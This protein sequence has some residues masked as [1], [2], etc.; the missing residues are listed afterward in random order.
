MAARAST[1]TTDAVANTLA[2]PRLRYMGSKYRLI[3][4]LTAVFAGLGGGR[5]LDAFSGSG[6][7]SY[8]LKA[9]GYEVSSNDFLAFAHVISRATVV[10]QSR[11]LSERDIERISGAP[12]DRRDFIQRTF[13]GL[14]FTADDRAF[15]D[16]AWSHIDRMRGPA[17]G[18]RH[19]GPGAGR[20][21]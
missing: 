19:S 3:E 6:V 15:L 17:A 16:S 13:A 9:L 4:P 14:Y 12:A 21:T 1:L 5:A 11:R 7:V 18:S 10:N 20:R 8:L 2:F